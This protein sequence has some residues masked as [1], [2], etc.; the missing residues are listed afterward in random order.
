[1]RLLGINF[2]SGSNLRITS[3]VFIAFLSLGSFAARQYDVIIVGAGMAGLTA[4]KEISKAGHSFVVL[5]ATN[6][7][8]GRALTDTKSFGFP[9]DKGA[10]WFHDVP[11]N[12]LVP[13]ADK[14][15]FHRVHTELNGPIFIDGRRATASEMEQ[16]SK[17]AELVAH[18]MKEAAD[19]KEDRAASEF[20]PSDAPF[21]GLIASNFGPL[22]NGSDLEVSSSIDTIE[23]GT[24][25]DDFLQ[26]GLG[27]FVAAFGK[28]VPVELGQ[29]VDRVDYRSNRVE[30]HT[31]KGKLFQGKTVLLTV[32]TGVLASGKIKFNPELPKWKLDAIAGLPMGLLTKIVIEFKSDVFAAE[33]P[34]T[35]VLNDGPGREDMAFVIKPLNA[36]AAV[37][38][39]GGRKA[40]SLETT[41]EGKKQLIAQTRETLT[42]M[43]G[44]KLDEEF[45]KAAVTNWGNTDWT[46][47]SYSSA[48]PGM[49]KMHKEMQKDV[50]EKVFFAGEACA[51]PEFNGSL[52]GAYDSAL[53]ASKS[54]IKALTKKSL[55]VRN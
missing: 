5:E 37:G 1:M 22:E 38:F 9:L 34:N 19:R 23:F 31:T 2:R 16:Y 26:E 4:A 30:V 17:T 10:A 35:W 15:G 50:D 24:G 46:L 6:R 53:D 21:S 14:M 28:D 27:T 49:S 12:P 51:K 20:F 13:I 55:P 41:P 3:V 43:Y 25:H 40:W 39:V 7:I 32:S 33:T 45:K 36:N 11:N 8:G 29:Q 44:S 54:I 42:K 52:P 47:G 18:A 48:L